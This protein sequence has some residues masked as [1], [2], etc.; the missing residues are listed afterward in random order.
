[1]GANDHTFARRVKERDGQSSGA[2]MTQGH[3]EIHRCSVVNGGH[4]VAAD[5]ERGG[6][7]AVSNRQDTAGAVLLIVSGHRKGHYEV[8]KGGIKK[9]KRI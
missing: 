8:G 2:G 5:G 3:G 1:M 7:E 9:R 6:G 4:R